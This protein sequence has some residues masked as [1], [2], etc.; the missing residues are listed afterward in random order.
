LALAFVNQIQLLSQGVNPA[1]IGKLYY[2]PTI[3]H[4]VKFQEIAK[5]S[6]PPPWERRLLQNENR[7]TQTTELP[8]ASGTGYDSEL[9]PILTVC[10]PWKPR[11]NVW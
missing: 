4:K 3:S 2:Y 6:P 8:G 1:S 10:S 5:L 11:E 7:K 9:L